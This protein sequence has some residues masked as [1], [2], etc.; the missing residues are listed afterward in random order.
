MA[1]ETKVNLLCKN[2]GAPFAAFLRQM[3]EHN[4]KIVCPQCGHAHEY[5][6]SE[7]HDLRSKKPT[8]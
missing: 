5:N 4:Q 3:A 6:S 8:A 2:C 7:L 1:E